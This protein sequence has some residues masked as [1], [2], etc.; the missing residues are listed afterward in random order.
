MAKQAAEVAMQGMEGLVDAVR[1]TYEWVSTMPDDA[2]SEDQ[3]TERIRSLVAKSLKIRGMPVPAGLRRSA[4]ES[5][6]PALQRGI[7]KTAISVTRKFLFGSKHEEDKDEP[8]IEI[9]E[10]DLKGFTARD[11]AEYVVIMESLMA[12][13]EEQGIY[14]TLFDPVNGKMSSRALDIALGNSSPAAPR[15]V[16]SQASVA[17]GSIP[18]DSQVEAAESPKRNVRTSISEAARVPLTEPEGRRVVRV[19]SA[20]VAPD[21]LACWDGD[22]AAVAEVFWAVSLQRPATLMAL[23]ALWWSAV[24]ACERSQLGFSTDRTS[25]AAIVPEYHLSEGILLANCARKARWEVSQTGVMLEE[26]VDLA[27]SR[28]DK[29]VT[30]VC[31]ALEYSE[32]AEAQLCEHACKAAAGDPGL[33]RPVIAAFAL[34]W[35][36]RKVGNW[37]LLTWQACNEQIEEALQLPLSRDL[38]LALVSSI[39]GN[40]RPARLASLMSAACQADRIRLDSLLRLLIRSN[41][42]ALSPGRWVEALFDFAERDPERL[43]AVTVVV[44]ITAFAEAVE[45]RFLAEVLLGCLD[46]SA[47]AWGPE[48]IARIL[49]RLELDGATGEFESVLLLAHMA[50][51]LSARIE[52]VAVRQMHLIEDSPAVSGAGGAAAAAIASIRGM[53]AS[54]DNTPESVRK[55]VDDLAS[56]IEALIWG[57]IYQKARVGLGSSDM[58]A[59]IINDLARHCGWSPQQATLAATAGLQY[60]QT[61]EFVK[62]V[63]DDMQAGM[64]QAASEGRADASAANNLRL[65]VGRAQEPGSVPQRAARPPPGDYRPVGANCGR[66][67][68]PGQKPGQRAHD[69]DGPALTGADDRNWIEQAVVGRHVTMDETPSGHLSNTVLMQ[70]TAKI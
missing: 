34:H 31:K 62:S 65:G 30:T 4:G 19:V 40:F 53:R 56:R 48:V 51:I 3:S 49:L 44:A 15:L 8:E 18:E 67:A 1:A 10:S 42:P 57:Y 9:L 12:N 2:F 26:L 66:S 5:R 50:D 46:K 61:K 23:L 70:P 35:H 69:E 68:V 28:A 39:T 58:A 45:P 27:G 16:G 7:S 25:R 33:R 43:R 17:T 14:N 13:C 29:L 36:Q 55:A 38:H 60:G 59:T 47:G 54:T 22:E 37:Q 21:V 63:L 52:R 11:V 32:D 24:S 6:R 64:R 20:L 41:V